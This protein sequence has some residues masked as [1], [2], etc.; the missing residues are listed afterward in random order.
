MPPNNTQKQ[1]QTAPP[2]SLIHSTTDGTPKPTTTKAIDYTLT[3]FDDLTPD[4]M[5]WQTTE[6]KLKAD[7]LVG[8][9]K[10]VVP[11]GFAVHQSAHGAWRPFDFTQ[12][13]GTKMVRLLVVA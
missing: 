13:L 11:N 12:S 1:S 7:G 6:A 8:P 9:Y 10:D 5:M 2:P 3:P 4:V